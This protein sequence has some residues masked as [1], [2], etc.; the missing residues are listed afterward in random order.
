M[1]NRLRWFT[2]GVLVGISYMV[3]RILT[4][5]IGEYHEIRMEIQEIVSKLRGND[6]D[7]DNPYRIQ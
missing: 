3:I 2:L 6:S 7:D 5:D 1:S 4:I